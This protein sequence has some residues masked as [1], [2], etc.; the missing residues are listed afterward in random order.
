MMTMFAMTL[1]GL[2]GNIYI[3]VVAGFFVGMGCAFSEGAI[4]AQVPA[5]FPNNSGSVAG[6]VGGIGTTGG[7][8]YPLAF[9]AA[10]LPNLHVG[11]AIVGTSMIPI[12]ALTAWVFQPKIS[13]VANKAGLLVSTDPRSVNEVSADD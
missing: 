8:V 3:A 4:F 13:V 9:S 11:Y 6:I 2:S 10:F 7:V 1:A 5:M 12:I